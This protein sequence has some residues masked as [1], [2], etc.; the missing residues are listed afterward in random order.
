MSSQIDQRVV[1]M[2]FDNAQFEA[3]VAQTMTTLQNLDQALKL[4]SSAKGLTSLQKGLNTV[5]FSHMS[6]GI[7]AINQKFSLMGITGMSIVY[8]LTSQIT[9]AITKTVRELTIA[10]VQQGF[11]EYEL[12]MGSIQTIMASTG[13]SLKT[14]NKYLE[15]LNT[16]SDKTIYSFSDMTNSIGKFTNAGVDLDTAVKAIQGI[17]NEAA[18]SGA[19]AQEA[20]RAMYNFAQALS[21]G[22]VK[23]ID[24]KSIENAN[25]A[26]VEFKT[27]LLETAVALGTLRKESDGTY[28]VI[29]K[30]ADK[31]KK[32]SKAAT[33]SASDVLTATQNFNDSLKEEWMTTEVLTTTL[34]KYADTTTDIGK[35][36]FAAAQDIKTYSMLMDTLKEA[37]GSGWSYTFEIIFGDLEQAKELWTGIGNAVGGFIDQISDARNTF[38]RGVFGDKFMGSDDI[39]RLM[40]GN[41]LIGKMKKALAGTAGEFKFQYQG[42]NSIGDALIAL[43]KNNGIAIDEMMEGGKNVFDTLK[44]GWLT[45]EIFMSDLDK[46]GNT[47]ANT[48]EYMKILDE[49]SNRVIRGDFG[50]GAERVKKLTEAGYKYNDVQSVVN[51]KLLGW[52]IKLEEV[53]DEQL[54]SIGYTEK[55]IEVLRFLQKEAKET[56]TPLNELIE[57]MSKPTGRTLLIQALANS[58]RAAGRVISDVSETIREVF[59]S[60]S[61]N[62]FFN[63]IERFEKFSE[64][65]MPAAAAAS[66]DLKDGVKGLAMMVKLG[67]DGVSRSLNYLLPILGSTLRRVLSI[68]IEKFGDLGRYLQK[69]APQIRDYVRRLVEA[70]RGQLKNLTDYLN[71]NVFPKFFD[72]YNKLKEKVLSPLLDRVTEFIKKG[73]E[74]LLDFIPT[75]TD[76]VKA[77]KQKLQ[78]FIDIVKKIYNGVKD[79]VKENLPKVIET[80]KGKF[81][82][83][84]ETVKDFFGQNVDI[85]GIKDG[86]STAFE[87]LKEKF[88]EIIESDQPLSTAFMNMAGAVLTFAGE[89]A[90]AVIQNTALKDIFDQIKPILDSIGDF[91]KDLFTVKIPEAFAIASDAMGKFIEHLKHIPV[92]GGIFDGLINSIETIKSE[93]LFTWITKSFDNLKQSLDKLYEGSDKIDPKTGQSKSAIVNLQKLIE[94]IRKLLSLEY[95]NSRE[96]YENV[97]S[98]IQAIVRG[99]TDGTEGFNWPVVE[100][101]LKLVA[102]FYLIWQALITIRSLKITLTDFDDLINRVAGILSRMAGV[103]QGAK[104][105]LNAEAFKAVAEGIAMIIGA[106]FLLGNLPLDSLHEVTHGMAVVLMGIAAIM[107]AFSKFGVKDAVVDKTGDIM[108]ALKA[109][110]TDLLDVIKTFVAVA[111]IGFSILS[112]AA[113]VAILI[114]VITVIAGLKDSDITRALGVMAKLAVGIGIFMFFMSLVAVIASSTGGGITAGFG[115]TILATAFAIKIIAGAISEVANCPVDGLLQAE[116]VLIVIMG[117]MTVM[118]AILAFGPSKGGVKAG[119]GMILAVVAIRLLIGPLKDLAKADGDIEKAAKAIDTIAVAMLKVA[120][121]MTIMAFI[122]DRGQIDPTPLIGIAVAILA[123]AGAFALMKNCNPGQIIAMSAAMVGL[124]VVMGLLT[125]AL[126]FLK[127][128]VWGGVIIFDLI[129]AGLL[130]VGLAALAFGAGVALA[131]T[132]LPEFADGLMY[133]F[134]KIAENGP[135]IIEAVDVIVTSVIMVLVARKGDLA[136]TAIAVLG[137]ILGAVLM[138]IQT[139][140]PENLRNAIGGLFATLVQLIILAGEGL[141]RFLGQFVPR[142]ASMIVPILVEAILGIVGGLVMSIGNGVA[143]IADTWLGAGNEISNL[144]YSEIEKTEDIFDG[145]TDHLVDSYRRQMATAENPFDPYA[146]AAEQG[147]QEVADKVN[148][149]KETITYSLAEYDR[150]IEQQT[151]SMGG[152]EPYAVLDQSEQILSYTQSNSDAMTFMTEQLGLDMESCQ[153]ILDQYTTGEGGMSFSLDNMWKLNTQSM[154]D[155]SAEFV[156]ATDESAEESKS[157]V[158]GFY[159]VITTEAQNQKGPIYSAS[160]ENARYMGLGTRDG[161]ESSTDMVT[162]AVTKVFTS[163][164][165]EARNVLDIHSPSGVFEDM[166]RASAEGYGEGIKAAGPAA[167]RQVTELFNGTLDRISQQNSKWRTA[168]TMAAGQF[169]SGLRS[170]S[171]EA[172]RAG[173]Q[174]ASAAKTGVGSI[175]PYQWETVGQQLVAGLIRGINSKAKAARNAAA[176]VATQALNKLKSVPQISSP[177]KVTTRYGE[178][179]GEGWVNGIVSMT[180]VSEVAASNLAEDSISAMQESVKK[181]NELM[182]EP[183]ELDPTI[184]PVLDLTDVQNGAAQLG[185]MLNMRTPVRVG[186]F[187]NQNDVMSEMVDVLRLDL[188][189]RKLAAAGGGGTTYNIT[190]N[191]PTGNA[192]DIAREIERIIVR[193]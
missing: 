18:V 92:I 75:I 31:T 119:I 115:A 169:S 47:A 174:I 190:V 142:L 41:D 81:E 17:S 64:T 128:F 171:Q 179:F 19:N 118:A 103:L 8:K 1:E 22:Y 158:Q 185:G 42:V 181:I 67:I 5:S 176:N 46:L 23:L 145:M 24:W 107:Y 94:P 32:A 51:N 40:Q 147:S 6:A 79:F 50:N 4:D 162:K 173:A 129:A 56:G 134:Q 186:G 85:T 161:L 89:V 36:A 68:A 13:E 38:L 188:R 165:D 112:V 98:S 122:A 14:V 157:A 84:S 3:A 183:L 57:Q 108:A 9:D 114:Y 168:A 25:M 65:L 133:L 130:L 45:A 105:K 131:A 154:Q 37:V 150:A 155:G 10:P 125:A 87:N 104:N 95:G 76:R 86:I 26:T 123:I 152:G 58:F 73:A 43:A 143:M 100:N 39:R 167:Q 60:F 78:P 189:N 52:E 117:I 180:R 101:L 182:L 192:R 111:A 151:Q 7:D 136:V 139:I 91:I 33:E 164:I 149:G 63:A 110:A 71:A 80:V 191:A 178:Y 140:G 141:I 69:L 97:K 35:K 126:T 124:V 28:R 148:A 66:K 21:A 83:F 144:I 177:S 93:G 163:M 102:A 120:A 127:D 132:K 12:K 59:G 44:N 96:I 72:V 29:D 61:S 2:R 109:F 30:N 54:K 11:T 106:M 99:I 156:T 62:T 170:K 27:E 53:S 88:K 121:V 193:R 16:Y 20:S 90:N 172:K 184:R 175:Q 137:Y 187:L 48:A 15:E 49:M 146:Q 34:Q 160:S 166:G 77:L 116:A 135:A 113:A 70:I 74:K 153:Q 82:E 159:N 138:M 55:Q